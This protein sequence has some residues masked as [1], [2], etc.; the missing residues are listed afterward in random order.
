MRQDP[1]I[2]MVGEIRDEE[3]ASTA[4]QAALTGHLVFSTLHT[5]SAA[6]VIPR[7]ID[8]KVNPKIISSALKVSL[9][10]RLVRK[11]CDSCKVA[12]ALTENERGLIGKVLGGAR[13]DVKE[14]YG[15][16]ENAKI[17]R[18]GGETA[19]GGLGCSKCHYTGYRGRV[20]VFEG[21][22]TDENIEKVSIIN[23]SEREVKKAALGQGILSL[24]EDGIVKVLSG[25]TTLEEVDRVVDLDAE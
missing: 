19:E 18:V 9:A 10:Q 12:D 8:L 20:G 3:T 7:L 23:P 15:N 6:G 2:I 25:V 4:I 13:A 24:K 22:L 5:N 21:I 16:L 11:L 14:K 17:W 1:D